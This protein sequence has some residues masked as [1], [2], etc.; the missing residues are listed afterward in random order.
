MN[1][2]LKDAVYGK[3]TR[4]QVE[5][6]AKLGGMNDEEKAILMLFHEGKTDTYIQLELGLSRKAYE[7]IEEAVRAKL[8]IAIFTCINKTYDIYD[9]EDP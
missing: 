7:R 8:T 6:M 2:V 3:G 1:Q 5:F 4:R 9:E